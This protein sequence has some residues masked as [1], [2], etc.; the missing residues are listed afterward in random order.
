[1]NVFCFSTTLHKGISYGLA[2]LFPCQY[3][4]HPTTQITTPSSPQLN[5]ASCT[6]T[7]TADPVY[8]LV[9]AASPRT[10]AV[11]DV[12][13]RW[14]YRAGYPRLL[15]PRVESRPVKKADFPI[16]EANFEKLIQLIDEIAEAHSITLHDGSFIRTPPRMEYRAHSSPVSQADRQQIRV[17][18]RCVY[19]KGLS[20]SKTWAK[21]VTE[22]YEEANM[23]CEPAREIGV[24]LFDY[25]YMDTYRFGP[26]PSKERAEMSMN[27]NMGQNYRQRI[28]QL[29]ENRSHMWQVMVPIG[30]WAE[31]SRSQ[32]HKM[33]IYFDALD[34]EDDVWDELEEAIRSILPEDI[35]VAIL[36]STG[37][38]LRFGNNMAKLKPVF[39]AGKYTRPPMPGC[40]ISIEQNKLSAGTMGGYVITE[41][42]DTRIRTTFGITN[43]HVVYGSK[44]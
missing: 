28:L 11:E 26:C 38:L 40:E 35:G 2:V 41:A 29:F 14:P 30:L 13:T 37:P 34:A 39:V 24:E 43:A 22:I 42:K 3:L 7:Y 19:E 5:M 4:F 6:I 8:R 33:V 27:W 31:G 16:S 44:F 32:D 23:L 10:I 21:A 20:H 12:D 15:R 1:M 36:Q 17:V 18:V 9:M 25:K